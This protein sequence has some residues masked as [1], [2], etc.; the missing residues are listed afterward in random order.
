MATTIVCLSWGRRHKDLAEITT[1]T[2][3]P[4][5][6]TD[7]VSTFMDANLNICDV[8]ERIGMDIKYTDFELQA[9]KVTNL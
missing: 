6:N 5:S 7:P 8:I 1:S 2:T 3:H 9:K 4:Y